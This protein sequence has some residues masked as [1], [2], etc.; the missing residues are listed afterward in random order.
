LGGF[1]LAKKR[2]PARPTGAKKKGQERAHGRT[3]IQKKKKTGWG[4]GGEVSF[5]VF[6]LNEQLQRKKRQKHT[7]A[8]TRKKNKSDGGKSQR[9]ASSLTPRSF[10]G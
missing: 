2:A 6:F 1:F 3:E 7:L 8:H 5:G 9:G 10:W 4:G